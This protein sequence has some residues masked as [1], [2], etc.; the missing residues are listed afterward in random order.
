MKNVVRATAAIIAV[1]IAGIAA[2]FAEDGTVR[3][4][5][6]WARATPGA[7][8]TGAVYLSIINAG[9]I[10]D[11]LIS[12]TTPAADRAETHTMKMENGVMEMRPLGP[13][14]IEPGKTVVFAPDGNHIMLTGLKAPLKE[15]GTLPLT[16]TFEHAGNRDVTASIARVGAMHAGEASKSPD[17]AHLPNMSAMPGMQH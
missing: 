2:S 7:A 1:L 12:I 14:T 9:S 10:P 6:V 4:G 3:I 11:R 13:V 5:E 8:K 17:A 16:L 15:G